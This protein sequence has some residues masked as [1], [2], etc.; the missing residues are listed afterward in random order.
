M[1]A[2]VIF[3]LNFF[4]FIR[5]FIAKLEIVMNSMYFILII[6]NF[7]V[8]GVQDSTTQLHLDDI[9]EPQLQAK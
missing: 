7:M 8:I 1:K 6:S 5:T 2:V 3:Y 4:C 9:V